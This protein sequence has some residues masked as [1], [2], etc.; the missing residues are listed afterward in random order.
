MPKHI[1]FAMSECE[2]GS[3]N[4]EFAIGQIHKICNNS[5]NSDKKTRVQFENASKF[6]SRFADASIS[7][8]RRL[9]L[10]LFY[11]SS[12]YLMSNSTFWNN[13]DKDSLV[14]GTLWHFDRQTVC[15]FRLSYPNWNVFSR[16][17]KIN[18]SLRRIFV[19]HV[20][21]F[22]FILL[23]NRTLTSVCRMTIASQ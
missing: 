17:G 18:W 5:E 12:I 9:I 21:Q 19:Y 23:S 6:I 14:A 3:W 4:C 1:C 7:D 8:G 22:K 11:Q 13:V 16:Y 2:N 15:H 20:Q 10:V